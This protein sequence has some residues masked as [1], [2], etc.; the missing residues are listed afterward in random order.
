MS[1]RKETKLIFEGW[2]K[3]LT[4]SKLPDD[5]VVHIYDFD[6]VMGTFSP[7]IKQKFFEM[8]QDPANEITGTEVQI[9]NTIALCASLTAQAEDVADHYVE[10]LKP[11]SPYYVITK[12]S[13]PVYVQK[14]KYYGKMLEFLAANGMH[15][16]ENPN[17]T[18]QKKV[19]IIKKYLQK[20]GAASPEDI[21]VCGNTAEDSKQTKA[22]AIGLRHK[23]DNVKFMVHSANTADGK[24]EATMVKNG[25]VNAGIPEDKIEIRYIG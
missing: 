23:S 8:S 14:V 22:E 13:N 3:H 6:G 25:L 16:R 21:F 17:T 11:A 4:E 1:S 19:T 24:K 10:L 5:S 15:M 7:T 2:R 20:S 12:F 9:K 18:P